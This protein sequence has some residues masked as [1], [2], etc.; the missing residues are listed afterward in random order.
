ME[1]THSPTQHIQPQ[2]VPTSTGLGHGNVFVGSHAR[3]EEIVQQGK[4]VGY[5][6]YLRGESLQT[7]WNRTWGAE[8]ALVNANELAERSNRYAKEG[9]YGD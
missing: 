2:G 7:F 8:G 6:V 4:V 9:R 1:H 5:R 3:A